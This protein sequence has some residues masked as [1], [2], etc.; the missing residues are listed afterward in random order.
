MSIFAKKLMAMGSALT[1]GISSFAVADYTYNISNDNFGSQSFAASC[2][3]CA[4]WCD[5][6]SFNAAWL[7][8]KVSGDDFQ[9]AVEKTTTGSGTPFLLTSKEKFHDLS[10]DLKSGFRIGLGFDL[11]N[12]GW[13]VYV[14]WTHFHASTHKSI[15]AVGTDDLTTLEAGTPSFLMNGFVDVGDNLLVDGYIKFDYDTVDIEFGKWLSFSCDSLMFRPHAGFRVADIKEKYNNSVSGTALA[16]DDMIF[17]NGSLQ[18][19]NH[20]KGFGVRVGLDTDFHFCDGWSL[21][22]RGAASAIWGNTRLKNTLLTSTLDITDQQTDYIKENYHQTRFITDL[23]FGIR[24]KTM[25]CDCYPL[26]I[27][28]AWEHHYLFS[29]NR[30]W[31]NDRFGTLEP[32]SGNIST[33]DVALQGLTLSA[34]FDF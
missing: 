23:S 2:N 4:N 15:N 16:S 6:I 32:T 9:Y 13:G 20:F 3:Q 5:N 27:E 11:P 7:Y 24:W 10:F 34:G 12:Y 28:L 26:T 18:V 17:V 30:Y 33:G 1:I 31:I 21:I 22:G 29:Q 25:A 8:W 14:D 19:E